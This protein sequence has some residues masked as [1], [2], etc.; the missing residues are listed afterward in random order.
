MHRRTP[1]AIRSW[2]KFMMS[3]DALRRLPVDTQCAM[4]RADHRWVPRRCLLTPSLAGE[5]AAY[6][7]ACVRT[8][9]GH[10][11]HPQVRRHV[12]YT[13]S[14]A[15]SA[16]HIVVDDDRSGHDPATP[17]EPSTLPP[18]QSTVRCLARIPLP[19]P[20][21]ECDMH[22]S[23][24]PMPRCNG[25]HV[26]LIRSGR[27]DTSRSQTPGRSACPWPDSH[28]QPQPTRRLV[29]AACSDRPGGPGYERAMS[30]PAQGSLRLSHQSP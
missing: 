14:L 16:L 23:A 10:G 3:E 4:R 15:A 20:S 6:E 13:I 7:S 2:A 12:L 24:E 28:R 18:W 25:R 1:T 8:A 27:T 26:L 30:M 5:G 19:L 22:Q 17:A 11:A 9:Q 21:G 29:A